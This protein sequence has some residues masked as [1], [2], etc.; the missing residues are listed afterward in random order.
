MD[1]MA[2]IVDPDHTKEQSDLGRHC[3]PRLVSLKT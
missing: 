1:G 3:L 2:N